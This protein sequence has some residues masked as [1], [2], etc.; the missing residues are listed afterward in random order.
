MFFGGL[1]KSPIIAAVSERWS[2]S[3][4]F[5]SDIASD[6]FSMSVGVNLNL[7]AS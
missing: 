1:R 7:S 4:A 2:G 3:N 5:M 6:I